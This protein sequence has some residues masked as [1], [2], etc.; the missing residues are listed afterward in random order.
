MEILNTAKK[1]DVAAIRLLLKREVSN[2]LSVPTK[3]IEEYISNGTCIYH[4]GVVILY[5]I[6]DNQSY[7]GVPI[8]KGSTLQVDYLVASV[9][10][11]GSAK[12]VF[13]KFLLQKKQVILLVMTTNER[14]INFYLARGLTIKKT[15]DFKT[16]SS[17]LLSTT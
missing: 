8:H 3:K 13:S 2:L 10:G 4:N 6:L 16:F 15:V 5:R 14:A 12:E 17:Y 7:Y 11:D 1:T 9:L